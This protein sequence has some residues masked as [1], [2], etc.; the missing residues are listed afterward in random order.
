MNHNLKSKL[1][2][3][4]FFE[5]DD[6]NCIEFN[7]IRATDGMFNLIMD[8]GYINTEDD[9]YPYEYGYS[10]QTTISGKDLVEIANKITAY[11]ELNMFDQL[12]FIDD[13]YCFDENGD[14]EF[15]FEWKDYMTSTPTALN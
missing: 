11:L 15:A 6:L 7:V 5:Y 10:M 13:A 12:V 4:L 9:D 1:G 14:T 8:V 2:G 3:L